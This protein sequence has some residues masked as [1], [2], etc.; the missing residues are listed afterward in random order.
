[1]E[2]ASLTFLC[3]A[4]LIKQ[5]PGQQRERVFGQQLV[6]LAV[7]DEENEAIE[8]QVAENAAALDGSLSLRISQ[9]LD[10]ELRRQAA[11]EHIPT[12]ALVRRLLTQ[13]VH[14]HDSSSITPAE[15]EE[16]AREEG[17]E[18]I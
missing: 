5:H 9:S 15:V 6:G 14:K 3:R 12:S 7:A 11:A 8:A 1:V 4:L 10:A 16:I 17:E 13:A 2:F 18:A